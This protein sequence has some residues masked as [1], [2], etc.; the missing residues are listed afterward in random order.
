MALLG[1]WKHRHLVTARCSAAKGLQVGLAGLAGQRLAD[2]VEQYVKSLMS[3]SRMAGL[4]P[5]RVA[6]SSPHPAYL[7][8]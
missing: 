8:G 7:Q 2:Y 6:R 5:Q 3:V 4:Q 1:Q